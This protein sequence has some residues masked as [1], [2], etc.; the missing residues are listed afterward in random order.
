MVVVTALTRSS[1]NSAERALLY[2]APDTLMSTVKDAI[3]VAKLD[4][5]IALC[6]Y[7]AVE[8]QG[9][10]LHLRVLPVGNVKQDLTDSVFTGNLVLL[11]QAKQSLHTVS[12]T[13]RYWQGKL[14][15]QVSAEDPMQER[16]AATVI[17]FI[18]HYC[19]DANI[20]LVDAQLR[21]GAPTLLHFRPAMGEVKLKSSAGDLG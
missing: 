15:A 19:V 16:A 2:V 6:L 3:L 21:V 12:P 14:V 17:E 11:E 9:L 18:R 10:L 20:K 5:T 4:A 1:S 8:E 7:D 13:A